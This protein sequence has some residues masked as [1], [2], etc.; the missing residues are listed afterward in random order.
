MYYFC[1]AFVG[2]AVPSAVFVHLSDIHFG[3]ERG[4]S[5]HIHNDVKEQL[6]ADAREVVNN[7]PSRAAHGILVTGDIAH[8]SKKKE[9]EDASGQEPRE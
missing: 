9:Y 5:V 4:E 3:E 8:S 1:C 2:R 6:V 7:L